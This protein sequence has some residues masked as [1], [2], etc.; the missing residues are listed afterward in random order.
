[1]ENILKNT[2]FNIFKNAIGEKSL[3]YFYKSRTFFSS[4]IYNP[5]GDEF[6]LKNNGNLILKNHSP[7]FVEDWIIYSIIRSHCKTW[8]TTRKMIIDEKDINTYHHFDFYGYED[9]KSYFLR[10][11][12]NG[13]HMRNIIVLSNN[14]SKEEILTNDFFKEKE[15]KKFIKSNNAIKQDLYLNRNFSEFLIKNNISFVESGL[16]SIEHCIAY[17]QNTLNADDSIL[18]EAGQ[19]V[20]K[21]FTSNENNKPIVDF[22]LLSVY[23]G[24]LNSNCLGYEFPSIDNLKNSG[25]ELINISDK[26][27]SEKGSLT[28]YTLVNKDLL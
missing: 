4:L 9:I 17:S 21:Y 8:M 15:I 23:Q 16:D 18:V 25:L 24:D 2:T 14:I 27:K 20:R 26:I 12:E 22:L 5:G 11:R 28:L 7:K 1:M 3:G 6:I 19:T 13:D 10:N